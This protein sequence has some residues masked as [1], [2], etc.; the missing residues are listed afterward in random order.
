MMDLK[1][2]LQAI[3]GEC[4]AQAKKEASGGKP[5]DLPK[6]TAANDFFDAS[7]WATTAATTVSPGEQ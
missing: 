1:K 7:A 4:S 3:K 2:A 5:I 6:D